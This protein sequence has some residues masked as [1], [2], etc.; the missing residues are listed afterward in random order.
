M[1]RRRFFLAPLALLCARIRWPLP[2]T[3]RGAWCPVALVKK[4]V[5]EYI[6]V[7][8]AMVERALSVLK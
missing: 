3:S 7:S 5:E 6:R 1:N 2:F 8:R 4:E